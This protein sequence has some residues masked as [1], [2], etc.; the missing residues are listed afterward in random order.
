MLENGGI[1][2]GE[3]YGD[4]GKKG[5]EQRGKRGQER[6]AWL[7]KETRGAWSERR[8]AGSRLERER[9]VV[10]GGGT[11]REGGFWEKERGVWSKG[12]RAEG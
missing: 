9:G 10:G 8:G 6:G 12:R 3:S 1:N 5:R 2:R 7:W 11:R 4:P